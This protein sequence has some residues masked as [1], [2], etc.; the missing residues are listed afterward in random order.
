MEMVVNV[1]DGW[2]WVGWWRW[3]KDQKRRKEEPST[4]FLEAD[5]TG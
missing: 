3:N 1:E 2:R 4:G 5:C